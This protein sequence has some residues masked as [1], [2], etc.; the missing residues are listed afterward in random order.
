M[1]LL[2]PFPIQ[3][4][5]ASVFR[6]LRLFGLFLCGRA[7]GRLS[8]ALSHLVEEPAEVARILARRLVVPGC[9]PKSGLR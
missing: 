8:V 6:D 1:G 5:V 3:Q 9:N 7:I 2:L 4:A